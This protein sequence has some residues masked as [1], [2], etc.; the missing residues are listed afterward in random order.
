MGLGLSRGWIAGVVAALI[1]VSS[2]ALAGDL[3]GAGQGT[4]AARGAAAPGEVA[5]DP[6]ALEALAQERAAFEVLTEG[7]R[8]DVRLLWRAHRRAQLRPSW[9]SSGASP[10]AGIVVEASLRHTSA[11]LLEARARVS[12]GEQG[13]GLR[14]EVVP[15][16]MG[17]GRQAISAALE[18]AR[19]V[20]EGIEEIEA[21]EAP[22][23][24]VV[25]EAVEVPVAEV[26]PDRAV[27]LGPESA[28]GVA[29]AVVPAPV[30]ARVAVEADREAPPVAPRSWDEAR[31]KLHLP[32]IYGKVRDKFGVTKAMRQSVQ[33]VRHTG[34]TIAAPQGHRVRSVE[35]GV[36]VLARPYK[37]FGQMVIVDH[38][39]GLH[40]IYAHLKPALVKEG[41]RLERGGLVGMV[42]NPFGEQPPRIYFELRREG[43]PVDPEGWF[44][45]VSAHENR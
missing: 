8:R 26:A 15:E 7:A 30:D 28:I 2:A 43:R 17:R 38:G 27:D 31:G 23:A 40:S 3:A 21:V 9:L 45:P 22:V 11:R 42:G 1:A 14:V 12:A 5:Q 32:L 29:L 24:E 19:A 37:G 25:E 35:E 4:A 44:A 41:V 13:R 34:W 36:V 39:D 10:R 20:S 6:A 18:G 16:A 33:E